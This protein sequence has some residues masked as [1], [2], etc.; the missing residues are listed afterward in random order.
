MSKLWGLLCGVVMATALLPAPHSSVWTWLSGRPFDLMLNV[1]RAC[2]H[3]SCLGIAIHLAYALKSQVT[4]RSFIHCGAQACLNQ[5]VSSWLQSIQTF[6]LQVQSTTSYTAS[7]MSEKLLFAMAITATGY[8]WHGRP[9]SRLQQQ[10]VWR[11]HPLRHSG[12]RCYAGAGCHCGVD[13][14]AQVVLRLPDDAPRNVRAG[15]SGE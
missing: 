4:S 3:L 10:S 15:C 14:A 6:T 7:E 2:G 12:R 8:K 11:R 13:S 5:C 9:A 1:H